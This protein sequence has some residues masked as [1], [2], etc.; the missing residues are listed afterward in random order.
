MV[1]VR[2]KEKD[3]ASFYKMSFLDKM[4]KCCKS[5]TFKEIKKGI[6]VIG[7]FHSHPNG[8]I[9]FSKRDFNI[10]KERVA[11]HGVWVEGLLV[12]K[13]GGNRCEMILSLFD[14]RHLTTNRN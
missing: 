4:F 13:K 14:K 10:I 1:Q 8:S 11:K 12:P 5:V 3:P 9:R 2:N 6:K 7:A